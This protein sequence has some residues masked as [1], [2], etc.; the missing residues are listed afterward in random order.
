MASC[1]RLSV[2]VTILGSGPEVV[3]VPLD[4]P[5]PTSSGVELLYERAGTE[6]P[7]LLACCSWDRDCGLVGAGSKKG[8]PDLWDVLTK[9]WA[10]SAVS[11]KGWE[12]PV[13]C[14]SWRHPVD[15][16]H[17]MRREQGLSSSSQTLLPWMK[18]SLSWALGWEGRNGVSGGSV[19]R[20]SPFILSFS[21]SS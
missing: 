20:L 2:Q 18:A 15:L 14:P 8:A 11:W 4:F 12:M 21:R 7:V 3:P 5:F 19:V 13:A 10:S 17:S 6:D 16:D 9:N 1:P